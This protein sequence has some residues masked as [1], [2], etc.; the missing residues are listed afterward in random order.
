VRAFSTELGS[1]DVAKA[2]NLGAFPGQAPIKLDPCLGQGH[3]IAVQTIHAADRA[4]RP[5]DEADSAMAEADQ[6]LHGQL[7]A[8]YVIH[9]YAVYIKLV[10][11]LRLPVESHDAQAALDQAQQMGQESGEEPKIIP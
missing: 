11:P 10:A 2:A 7:G 8:A 3:P 4:D 6:M 5:G 1:L 9:R